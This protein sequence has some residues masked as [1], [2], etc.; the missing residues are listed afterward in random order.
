MLSANSPN[1]NQKFSML[2][3]I[4]KAGEKLIILIPYKALLLNRE[5][6][7]I[8]IGKDHIILQVP[9]HQFCS[10]IHERVLL[11]TSST[12]HGIV[13]KV[14]EINFQKGM[15]TLTDFNLL[16]S[17]WYD[18][19][20]ERVEPNSPTSIVMSVAKHRIR[21]RLENL[22]LHG[23]GVLLYTKNPPQFPYKIGDTLK[24]EIDLGKAIPALKMR[25]N[26]VTTF[27]VGQ[28]LTHLGLEI[29][30]QGIQKKIISEYI[31]S[32]K[33]DILSEIEHKTIHALE[34]ISSM[35]LYF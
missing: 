31:I 34:P 12:P 8:K 6:R 19:K 11:V 21:G 15:I 2:N 28:Y 7:T 9:D 22:S 20:S 17:P 32:R 16:G 10:T 30:P 18:R 4:L 23:L 14:R 27:P 35:D 24:A 5:V 3:F 29:H 33:H 1:S 13:A 25:T 26:L